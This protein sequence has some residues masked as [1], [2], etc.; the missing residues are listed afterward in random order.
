MEE[1]S[2]S[3][4]IDALL[5]ELQDE[6]TLSGN[7][8]LELH[9]LLQVLEA[10]FGDITDK[11]EEIFYEFRELYHQVPKDSPF[12]I[13]LSQDSPARMR[14]VSYYEQRNPEVLQRLLFSE[15]QILEQWS[16][17]FFQVI[18][19]RSFGHLNGVI[20]NGG[21][22]SLDSI[23]ERI[24]SRDA[25]GRSQPLNF[26]RDLLR[27]RFV[28]ETLKDVENAMKILRETSMEQMVTI[29][30]AYHSLL[31]IDWRGSGEAKPYVA[32]NFVLKIDD[33]LTYELQLL[34]KRA[35]LIGK[36]DHPVRIKRK[37]EL[38]AELKNY[39]EALSWGSHLIDFREYLEK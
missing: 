21:V 18:L 38:S 12:K 8:L 20:Q 27:G 29:L 15:R 1:V 23:N 34:T 28:G 30:N 19:P 36:L 3:E 16:I 7:E 37:V 6:V 2:P 4:K 9:S 22:K 11:K 13:P 31:F 39:L 14:D 24:T 32:A 17:Y 35:A 25:D 33:N 5:L 26:M 10:E